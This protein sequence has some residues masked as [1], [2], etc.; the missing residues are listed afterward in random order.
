MGRV[1]MAEALE[2]D[3]SEPRPEETAQ[4]TVSAQEKLKMLQDPAV[5]EFI[6][7][8]MPPSPK[9]SQ[10]VQATEEPIALVSYTARL[11]P[12]TV[13]SIKRAAFENKM[14]R[15]KPATAQAIVQAALNEYIK[16]HGW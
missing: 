16:K 11:H 2:M 3:Q 14:A 12:D 5:Q 6:K 13:E 7:G 1:S 10:E 4:G 9:E 8:G 15:R